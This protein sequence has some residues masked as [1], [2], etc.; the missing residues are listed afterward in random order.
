MHQYVT[1]DCIS[2]SP[3]QI[4]EIYHRKFLEIWKTDALIEELRV[5]HLRMK[6]QTC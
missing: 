6:E 3:H 2:P 1:N 4:D 5:E